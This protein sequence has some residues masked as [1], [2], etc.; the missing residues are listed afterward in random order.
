MDTNPQTTGLN[1]E[2]LRVFEELN[3][4]TIRDIRA[5]ENNPLYKDPKGYGKKGG[6]IRASMDSFKNIND[7]ISNETR[8]RGGK[9]SGDNNVKSGHWDKVTNTP[10]KCEHCHTTYKRC[11]YMQY[12]GEFCVFSVVNIEEVRNDLLE[13]MSQPEVEKKYRIGNPTIRKIKQGYY[14]DGKYPPIKV[15]SRRVKRTCPHCNTTTSDKSAHFDNCHFKG[16]K[17]EK[18]QQHLRK[19]YSVS[20]IARRF[21]MNWYMIQRVRDGKYGQ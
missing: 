21:G 18:I 20:M 9:T 1:E 4:L 5:A 11:N 7:Y 3:N 17:L 15:D 13:G 10:I 12:H 8:S 16:G 2:Q 6:D 19:G 14:G